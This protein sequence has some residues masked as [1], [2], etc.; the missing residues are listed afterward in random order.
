[1]AEESIDRLAT[2][3]EDR[4][5]RGV[6]ISVLA[7]A[8]TVQF[9]LSLP[10]LL[11]NGSRYSLLWPQVTAFVLFVVVAAGAAVFLARGGRIPH[12]A[13][14]AGVG[15]ALLAAAAAAGSAPPGSHL[16]P[17]DWYFGL[18][19]WHGV[20][21]LFDLRL[22]FLAA[23][24]ATVLGLTVVKMAAPGMP[25]LRTWAAMAVAAVSVYG[26]QLALG[27]LGHAVQRISVRARKAAAQEE[28]IRTEEEAAEHR[29]RDHRQR[30][31]ALLPTLVPLLAGLGYGSLDP[32]DPDVR[33][34][35]VH[36]AAKMRRLF[37]ES[38]DVPDPLAH[39]LRAV[40][41][42]AE[43]RGVAVRFA[44]RGAPRTPP[45]EV[46]RELIEPVSAMLAAVTADA[47][48]TLVRAS[49]RVRVSA[50]G[51]AKDYA[52]PAHRPGRVQVHHVESEG[53]A[54]VE[55]SWRSR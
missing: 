45:K 23:F 51:D 46:R 13:R 1:M 19:G 16:E 18:T 32:G 2:Q 48:V 20:L 33:R 24:L 3:I 26:F 4:L 35:S 6:R 21:L 50:V 17:A 55:T 54:W 11:R 36:E 37:A 29:H 28:L 22:R 52:R 10:E 42:V 31:A 53:R 9:S 27:L 38:D 47:R 8:V 25:D 40:I 49:D 15:L 41:A 12:G 44:V 14:A 39:E 5:L 30:Y 43:R 34:R 7:V